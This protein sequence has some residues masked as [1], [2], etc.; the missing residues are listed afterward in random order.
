MK[1]KSL[2]LIFQFVTISAIAQNYFPTLDSVNH[3]YYTG[4]YLPVL[5]P[6]R[7]DDCQYIQY[8]NPDGLE[9]YTL[10]DT[11]IN[12]TEYK[13]LYQNWQGWYECLF[14]FIRED[15]ALQRVYFQNVIDTP[16][17]VLYD[18]LMQVGDSIEISF[19]NENS[20]SYFKSGVYFLDSIK[21]VMIKAGTRRAF[22]LN[23]DSCS[24]SNTLI[25]IESVGNQG[26]FI[27][28]YCA[29]YYGDG[30][31]WSCMGFP[32]KYFYQILTCFEHY[33]KVYFDSCTHDIALLGGCLDYID[34]C[35]YWNICSGI[36]ELNAIGYFSLSP[37]PSID[38]V[39]A[40]I[41]LTT[42]QKFEI[43]IHDLAGRNRKLDISSG[44]AFT[45]RKEM[46]ID[47]NDFFDGLYLVELRTE[48]GSLYRKLV[49]QR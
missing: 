11:V 34:S 43:V 37:N 15:T 26:D 30:F 4:N 41:E 42:P 33:Q 48:Q 19:F 7:T 35:H 5:A 17:I 2:L 13:K 9:Y 22:Y 32:T 44:Y 45:D 18:F 31:Y 6:V 21:N 39:T 14:G 1:K 12:G 38:Q 36:E 28:P 8:G 46:N 24:S 25:W 27:Y 23:C 40:T 16:E 29:N 3:W 10:G 49:I 20:N 47:L